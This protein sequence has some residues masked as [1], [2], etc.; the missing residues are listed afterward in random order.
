MTE[1]LAVGVDPGYEPLVV[2]GLEFGGSSHCFAIEVC[3]QGA[4]LGSA[5]AGDGSPGIP[6]FSDV[7]GQ[8]RFAVIHKSVIGFWRGQ[9]HFRG[10]ATG[11][12]TGDAMAIEDGLDE[13]VVT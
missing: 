8:A 1:S 9:V 7:V 10:L 3:Q 12:M 11:L 13:P 2:I 5:G 4:G 6:S